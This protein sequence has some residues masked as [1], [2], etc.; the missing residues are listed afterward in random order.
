MVA[1]IEALHRAGADE[2]IAEEFETSIEIFTRVLARYHVPRNI[3]RAETRALRGERYAHAA[4]PERRRRRL[5]GAPGA[6]GRRHD[7]PLPGD[8]GEPGGGRIA[9]RARPA[10]A[11]AAPPSSPWCAASASQTNPPAELALEPGDVLVL[12]GSHAEM[13]SAFGVLERGAEEAARYLLSFSIFLSRSASIR[14][15]SRTYSSSA[16][17]RLSGS[18]TVLQAVLVQDLQLGEL[19]LG[20]PPRLP[21]PRPHVLR[22]RL[23]AR[24]LDP[25][26]LHPLERQLVGRL[27][28]RGL[29]LLRHARRAYSPRPRGL[30]RPFRCGVPQALLR[31]GRSFVSALRVLVQ[32]LLPANTP[33]PPAPRTVDCEGERT[34]RPALQRPA[35][36][37]TDS[38]A[39]AMDLPE[40]SDGWGRRHFRDSSHGAA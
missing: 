25:L 35:G 20:L 39:P 26:A 18:Q 15:R 23:L 5:A 34:E 12:V 36:P 8:G 16:S 1:E 13:E 19:G 40:R 29:V 38:G 14:R 17:C 31:A 33:L 6:A 30:L 21:H 27:H 2:V 11:A 32:T 3:I 7:R 28:P 37:S 4:L 22:Q 10:P 9:P 24:P